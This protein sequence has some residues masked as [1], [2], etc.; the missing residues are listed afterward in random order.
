MHI[1]FQSL[2]QFF[3][4]FWA[5]PDQDQTKKIYNT[6]QPQPQ[7]HATGCNWSLAQPVADC[8]KTGSDISNLT[9]FLKSLKCL[10]VS[11][12]SDVRHFR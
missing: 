8:K 1:V 4:P 6:M 9:N 11:E 2:V 5:Q 12:V 3:L 10:I 7:P